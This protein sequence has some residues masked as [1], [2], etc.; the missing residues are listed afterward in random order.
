MTMDVYIPLEN[1]YYFHSTK[2][3]VKNISHETR[4]MI[5]WKNKL[6]RGDRVYAN[7]E[8]LLSQTINLL[9]LLGANIKLLVWCINK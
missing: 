4:Q 2:Y 7:D 6:S 1:W 5:F 8:V 3:K 9:N